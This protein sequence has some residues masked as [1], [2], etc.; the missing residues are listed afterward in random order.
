VVVVIAIAATAIL[1]ALV[2]VILLWRRR[3]RIVI[4]SEDRDTLVSD[5]LRLSGRPDRIILSAD[6]VRIPIEKKNSARVQDS[7]RA[8]LG[9]YFILMEDVYGERPPY[10][11][12]ALANDREVKVDNTDALR[13]WVMGLIHELR[14][15]S[16]RASPFA[17]KCGSCGMRSS[18]SYRA[19]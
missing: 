18:C 10:G 11:F 12:V 15:G 13:V 6:G 5:R 14:T 2:V 19:S 4:I 16:G 1:F 3:N 7:H 17:A 8:Q 9:A